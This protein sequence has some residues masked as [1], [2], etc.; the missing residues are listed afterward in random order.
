MPTDPIC[1]M[2]VAETSQRRLEIEGRVEFFCSDKCLERYAAGERPEAELLHAM[3]GDS[4]ERR[5]NQCRA[6]ITV[7]ITRLGRR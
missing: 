2:E 3:K 7:M 5:S 4:L 1:G 6:Q